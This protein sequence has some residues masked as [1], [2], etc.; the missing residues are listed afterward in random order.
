ME[1]EESMKASIEIF[2]RDVGRKWNRDGVETKL[3]RAIV[4]VLTF[5]LSNKE[6]REASLENKEKVLDAFK[7]LCIEN[8]DF[9]SSIEKTTKSLG[10]TSNRFILWGE[11]LRRVLNLGFKIPVREGDRIKFS[12]FWE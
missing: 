4:D 11:E 12:D 8:E 6:I 1:F 3:N 9:R 5:Y 2:G 10:S 7:S